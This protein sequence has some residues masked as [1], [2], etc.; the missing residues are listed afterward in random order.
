VEVGANIGTTTLMLAQRASVLAFEPVPENAR[1]L[2]VNVAQNRLPNP[3]DIRELA[4]SNEPGTVVMELHET[5]S[6]DH[7]VRLT[8]EP[9]AYDEQDRQVVEVRAVTLDFELAGLVPPSVWMDAQGHEAHVMAGATGLL[10]LRQ[11]SWVIEYF[12]YALRR[13]DG[14]ELLH[15]LIVEHFSTVIDMAHGGTPV[16]VPPADVPLLAARYPTPEH[17]TDLILIP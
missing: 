5:N 7:R 17:Y 12:P 16:E 14:L 6:G 10:D 1:L 8:D 4:L 9:G 2:R 13:A 11:T 3:V 15:E